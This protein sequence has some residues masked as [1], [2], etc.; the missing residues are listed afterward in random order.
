MSDI[1]VIDISY[2]GFLNLCS[3]RTTPDY[4]QVVYVDHLS[5]LLIVDVALHVANLSAYDT[6]QEHIKIVES[7]PG[8][9]LMKLHTLA[10]VANDHYTPHFIGNGSWICVIKNTEGYLNTLLN[11][12]YMKSLSDVFAKYTAEATEILTCI[13]KH[14]DDF[15]AMT[16]QHVLDI[17]NTSPSR[18]HII[19]EVRY[20][21]NELYLADVI[22]LSSSHFGKLGI[23]ANENAVDVA[24]VN[25]SQ[26][27][28]DIGS[29]QPLPVLTRSHVKALFPGKRNLLNEEVKKYGARTGSTH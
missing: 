28:L 18:K 10:S 8:Q 19:S 29:L 25:I 11:D 12:P 17:E 7:N 22:H 23:H 14:N 2:S 27:W 13:C 16:A 3:F 9:D 15:Y 1:N 4:I 21:C 5:K 6:F 24:L 26:K 20:E